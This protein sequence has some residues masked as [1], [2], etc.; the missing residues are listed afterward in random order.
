[1][2]ATSLD[3]VRELRALVGHRPLVLAGANLLVFDDADRLLL[4]RRADDGL[5]CIIGG[6]VEPGETLEDA[7]HRELYEETG[8]EVD[9]LTLVDVFSGP[10]FL[11]V[12]PNGDQVYP[13][14]ALYVARGARGELRADGHEGL[15][16]AFFALDAL[17]NDLTRVSRLVLQRYRT[18]EER[19]IAARARPAK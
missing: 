12:Y 7:A 3:Y 14:G 19:L 9:D 13:V 10:E 5:W 4:Q 18:R 11:M 2:E 15:E 1:M 16:L 17:P 6:S 8:L